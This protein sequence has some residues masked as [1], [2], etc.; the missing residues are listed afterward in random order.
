MSTLKR[1][2]NPKNNIGKKCSKENCPCDY[3]KWCKRKW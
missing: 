3:A 1:K 2:P